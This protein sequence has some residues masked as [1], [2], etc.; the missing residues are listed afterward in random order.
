MFSLSILR[1]VIS[2]I[3]PKRLAVPSR[4]WLDDQLCILLQVKDARNNYQ[5]ELYDDDPG[6]H[7]MSLSHD[8][9]SVRIH[10]RG[11][12]SAGQTHSGF[13]SCLMSPAVLVTKEEADGCHR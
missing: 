1:G 4:R 5:D 6:H 2:D 11:R 7:R 9:A 10:L 12:I 13:D 3:S 8:E